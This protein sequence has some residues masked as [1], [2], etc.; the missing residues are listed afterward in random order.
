[1]YHLHPTR[2]LWDFFFKK[3]PKSV[4]VM[5]RSTY[6]S[7]LLIVWYIFCKTTENC[8]RIMASL[9]SYSGV[10]II[11]HLG[12]PCPATTFPYYPKNKQSFME[13]KEKPN[14]QDL[15]ICLCQLQNMK[16]GNWS[17]ALESN[18][19]KDDLHYIKYE[20]FDRGINFN[21]SC[22]QLTAELYKKYN[23]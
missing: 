15:L 2:E 16:G 9:Q 11:I 17:A 20:L 3:R 10:A 19:G 5:E 14:S 22:A 23:P 13:N 8:R 1:M 12:S 7:S 18:K 21:G 6:C 4:T